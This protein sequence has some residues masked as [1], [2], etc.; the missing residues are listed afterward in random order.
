M[1]SSVICQACR[2]LLLSITSAVLWFATLMVFPS[3]K[4]WA[5]DP[6]QA[7][8]VAPKELN[9]GGRSAATVTAFK[10]ADRAPADLPVILYLLSS[11]NK[12]LQW[13]NATSTGSSG[14]VTMPFEV[15]RLSAGSY[16]IEASISGITEALIADTTLRD[17][18]AILIETDK[19]IYKPA[20]TVQGRVLLLDNALRPRPGEVE[21]TFYD[22]KGI[23][24]DRK[25]LTANEFGIAPFDI[26]LAREV[27][28]GVWKI[29]ASQGGVESSRDVRVENYVLPRYELSARFDRS[30]VLVDEAIHGTV[31][32]K[33]FF[34]KPVAGEVEVTAKRYVATWEVFGTA[35]GSLQDGAYA[36][37][38]PPAGFVAGTPGNNGLG[39]ITLDIVAV[40]ST[41]YKQTT[42]ELLTVSP[43]PVV[44]TLISKTKDLKPGMVTEI[45]V[46]TETPDGEPRDES[47]TGEAV[48]TKWDGAI[49]DTKPFTV[50]TQNGAATFSVTPPADTSRGV[51]TARVTAAGK[52]AEAK[53]ELNAAYSP[54]SSFLAVS[55]SGRDVPAKVGEELVFTAVATHPGTLFY[56]VY[57]GGRTVF[58]GASANREIR[59]V[60]APDMAPKAKLVAY[61]INPDNEVSADT[62]PFA[63]DLPAVIEVKTAVSKDDPKPG[64]AITLTIDAGRRAMIGLA[65][66]DSSV[67]ALGKSRLHLGEV[68]AEL[69]RRF[70]EPQIE[71]HDGGGDPGIV[72]G[73]PA[74]GPFWSPWGRSPGA[75]EVLA[76]AGLVV[77]FTS[78]LQVPVGRDV[79]KWDRAMMED[80]VGPP[81]PGAFGGEP[82]V[83]GTGEAVRV[84]Q[85]FPETWVWNPVLLTDDSGRAEL[86]LEVP[87]S[88]TSWEVSAVG[89]TGEGVGF[90]ARKL[91]VFQDFF[92][93]PDIPVSV[94]RGEEFPIAVQIYNYLDASQTV[95]LE[96]GS[97]DWFE[98]LGDASLAV[99][100][101]AGSAMAAHFPIR[102]TRVGDF[103]VEILARGSVLADAV[104]RDIRIEPE[105]QPAEE[106]FNSVIRAGETVPLDTSLPEFAVPDSGKALLHITPSPIAQTLSGVSDL[107]GMPYGCGEQNMIF[108]AP[109]VEVLRYLKAIDQL[110]PAVQA[111]AEYFI[112]T[113]YQRELTFQT[114][115]GGF[116]AFGGAEGSLW[117]TAFVLSTFSGAREVRDIDEGVLASAAGMLLGRQNDDGSF[118]TD[119]FLIHKEMDGGLSNIYAMSAYVANAL[120]DYGADAVKPGLEKAAQY[121]RAQRS[122]VNDDAYSLSI[123]AVALGKVAGFGDAAT[124][125]IDR[126][127][128]LAKVD[129]IGTH[130]EPYPIETTGYAA[131]ALLAQNRP[132]A[133]SAIEWLSTQRNSLGGYGESTQ[134]TVVAI[135]A[136]VAAA[137]KVRS[138]LN[139]TLTVRDGDQTLS[140]LRV[141][142]SNYDLLQS[143]E[144][145]AGRASGLTLS[146][147]GSGN[148]GYQLARRFNVPGDRL[149]PDRDMGIEVI[150]DAQGIEVDDLVDVIVRVRYIGPKKETGMT[151]VD[152][153]VPTGFQAVRATLDAL[154]S[155]KIASRVEVAGRKVIIY[156][157]GLKTDTPLE[158]RFQVKALYPV[159]A[160][161]PI[162]LVYEYYDPSIRGT[163][164]GPGLVVLAQPS[165]PKA[166]VR[167]DMNADGSLDISDPVAILHYLFLGKMFTPCLDRGDVNDDGGL[168]VTDPI[169]LLEFLFIGGAK[170]MPPYPEAG[171]DPTPDGLDC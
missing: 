25:K 40:D 136:L 129:G 83:S 161:P 146:S 69:E 85:H 29:R 131:L 170:P 121:L 66:V 36:F 95:R 13:L 5:G 135:R 23:R 153:G 35:K 137:M 33:Y 26:A 142:D 60:A 76:N 1:K 132:Q 37:S 112:N 54:T 39:S 31:E 104:V 154:V 56:D 102:P 6:Y 16:K 100:V 99:D 38:L 149:P 106:V 140:Q 134:D 110:L 164:R 94:T 152:I 3:G 150:Y 92:I 10:T 22:A 15:P 47:V 57:A 48:F 49:L 168:D 105:G 87:D 19:P 101:P 148:V 128:E 74:G 139:V 109:D 163:T 145:P 114:D 156:I 165:D 4:A 41:G 14:H 162:S 24:I 138:D 117:L 32:A 151:I 115:D 12:R 65:I 43:A 160:E 108:L 103:K 79:W 159:R 61:L 118:R 120:A 107:L 9:A 62:A 53:L 123:A 126:L 67:L 28:F 111:E 155:D 21:V 93:E 55:R 72:D 124:Q 8:L 52:T 82:P 88:I 144:L 7:M 45:L 80:A 30:W 125:V 98:L 169:L 86:E 73:G 166:F 46:T 11:D 141:N 119:D 71:I 81:V 90:G 70:L 68:F 113:G 84:R 97:G 130:W 167:G 122:A 157:D 50:N 147:E 89:S 51:F 75:A 2:S 20:Q 63:V 158:F 116:A 143:V 77:A 17:A 58:S 133:A 34:G 44:V 96:F 42:T 27:N 171:H 127:L 59:F 64:D 91:T 18:P 78:G